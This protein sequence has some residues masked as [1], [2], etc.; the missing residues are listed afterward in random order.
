MPMLLQTTETEKTTAATIAG[1]PAF[2]VGFLEEGGSS[3]LGGWRSLPWRMVGGVIAL[4]DEGVS[5]PFVKSA[6]LRRRPIWVCF[7]RGPMF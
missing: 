5:G 7:F 1:L 4:T 2:L 3:Q 6:D